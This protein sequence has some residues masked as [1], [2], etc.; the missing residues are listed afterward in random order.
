ML[1]GPTVWIYIWY[2]IFLLGAVGL[3]AAL[4]WGRRTHYRNL[5]E[6]LRACG[7]ILVSSGLVLLLREVWQ[8]LGQ[9]LLIV[10]VGCFVSAFILGRRSGTSSHQDQGGNPEAD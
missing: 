2:G 7:T 1:F 4:Y 9:A 8:I 5:D 6:I 3:V 10:A